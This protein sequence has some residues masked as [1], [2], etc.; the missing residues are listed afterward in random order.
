MAGGLYTFLPLV[1]C[2]QDHSAKGTLPVIQCSPLKLVVIF[3]TVVCGQWLFNWFI[4][5]LC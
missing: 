2:T 4:C 3:A 1:E 5:W